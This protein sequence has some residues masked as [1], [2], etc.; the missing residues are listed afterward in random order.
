MTIRPFGAMVAR[1]PP[2]YYFQLARRWSADRGC[3]FKSHEGRTLFI[4]FFDFC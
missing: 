3:G 4:L 2:I 1:G